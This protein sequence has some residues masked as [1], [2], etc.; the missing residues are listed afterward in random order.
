M[1]T[2]KDF[3]PEIQAKIPEYI[4]RYTKGVFDGG[5]YKNFNL[6]DAE[7]LI[8]WNYEKCKYKKPV[9]L[10]AENPYEMQI[11]FNYIVSNKATWIPIYIN[12]CL[13]NGLEL[14]KEF[15][16]LDSQLYSQLRSQLRSQL[17]SQLGSQ[18]GSQL[19]SQLDSQLRSQLRSQLDSQLGSQMKKYN[20][21]YLWTTNIYSNVTAAWYKFIKDEFKIDCQIGIELDSWNNIYEKSNVYS[22]IFSELVCIVSKY[23]IK[24]YRNDSNNLHNTKG[25]AVEWG[26]FCAETN[27][28]GYY[29]NGRNIKKKIFDL[30]LSG[31]VTKEDFIKESNEENKAAIYEIFGQEKMIE[32]LQAKEIDKGTFVHANGDLEEVI[33]YKTKEKFKEAGNNPL[34]WVRFICP[35][36]GT[37]YLIDVEPKYN[38]ARLAAISTSPL[39]NSIEEYS[40]S[41]RT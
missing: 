39:F 13:K 28:D 27:F 22:A 19:R 6:K 17:D 10:V 7:E 37:N 18:L 41:D 30:C 32:L 16:Q 8:H 9:V 29:I 4:K 20:E 26:S 5:R 23:P 2:L 31:K 24:V 33:L 15:S 40:F 1:K 35:S 38:D 3:T 25:V 36:T 34:A 12:Y 21:M 14:S 11:M